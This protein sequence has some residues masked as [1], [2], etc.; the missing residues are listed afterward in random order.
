MSDFLLE[1]ED[2]INPLTL[3]TLDMTAGEW[4]ELHQTFG[5]V[6]D[7]NSSNIWIVGRSQLEG[8]H[9][10]F[11]PLN[12]NDGNAISLDSSVY[13]VE[14]ANFDWDTDTDETLYQVQSY[15]PYLFHLYVTLE[16]VT[17]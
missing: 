3:G 16:T 5:Y 10:A 11:L 9:H 4:T 17:I 8:T 13:I 15:Q 12:D 14:K 1:F 7:L 2:E 6:E